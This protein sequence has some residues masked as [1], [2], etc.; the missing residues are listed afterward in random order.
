MVLCSALA[1]VWGLFGSDHGH[2]LL[3][4]SGHG[5]FGSDHGLFGSDHGHVFGSGHGLGLFGSDHGHVV[6]L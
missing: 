6:R 2:P 5:L 3:F 1:M 4:G